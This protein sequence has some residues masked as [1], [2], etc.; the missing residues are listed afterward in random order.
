MKI[1]LNLQHVKVFLLKVFKLHRYSKN[2]LNFSKKWVKHNVKILFLPYSLPSWDGACLFATSSETFCLV[3]WRGFGRLGLVLLK[4]DPGSSCFSASSDGAAVGLCCG[5]GDAGRPPSP[6]SAHPHPLQHGG[7]ARWSARPGPHA[8][9]SEPH[10]H[11]RA[12]SSSC[13]W[14]HYD[15]AIA[16]STR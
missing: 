10:K 3:L 1:Q 15:S 7:T 4:S 11:P 2:K 14:R 9:H 6:Q 12:G 5:W 16:K 8:A 13:S